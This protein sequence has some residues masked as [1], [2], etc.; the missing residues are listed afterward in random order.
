MTQI[1]Q[2]ELID[3]SH[4]PQVQV[5][6]VVFVNTYAYKIHP[7]NAPFFSSIKI[8]FVWIFFLCDVKKAIWFT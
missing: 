7:R 3:I 6:I 8:V 4:T 1:N 5:F 2:E